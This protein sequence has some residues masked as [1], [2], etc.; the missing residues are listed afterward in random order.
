M[1]P[2]TSACQTRWTGCL[3]RRRSACSSTSGSAWWPWRRRCCGPLLVVRLLGGT[4]LVEMGGWGGQRCGESPASR[5]D[6][7]AAVGCG[8]ERGERAARGWGVVVRR[9]GGQGAAELESRPSADG[10]GRGRRGQSWSWSQG[11]E[12]EA[13]WLTA[14]LP[15]NTL[16][17]ELETSQ[18]QIEEQHHHKVPSCWP[19]LPAWEG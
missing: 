1:K 7:A 2:T 11:R 13:S 4:E 3:L 8:P 5:W 17:Q 18:R 12:R 10:P 15:Q 16:I 9:S 6:G 14:D 19:A